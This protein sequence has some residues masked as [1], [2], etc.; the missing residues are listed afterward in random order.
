MTG[1][2]VYPNR[3]HQNQDRAARRRAAQ[4]LDEIEAEAGI[5]RRKLAGAD[6]PRST[7]DGDDTQL[8][9]GKVRDLTAQLAIIGVL[10]DV[11]AW[12]AL[13]HAEGA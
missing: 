3:E 12:H 10:R 2:P 5:L 6:N 9:A 1:E 4:A 13:D 8:I 11:R 7:V